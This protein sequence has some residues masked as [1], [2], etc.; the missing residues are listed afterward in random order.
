MLNKHHLLLDLMKLLVEVTTQDDDLKSKQAALWIN[1]ISRGFS[2]LER[3]LHIKLDLMKRNIGT[4]LSVKQQFELIVKVA[5]STY[6][7]LKHA[8]VLKG[9]LPHP[10]EFKEVLEEAMQNPSQH[11]LLFLDS[12]CFMSR[13]PKPPLVQLVKIYV[14]QSNHDTAR[15]NSAPQMS[16]PNS[17]SHVSRVFTV[18]SLL[19]S[20]S[21]ESESH[22]APKK[23]R[24]ELQG[25]SRKGKNESQSVFL[26]RNGH[27]RGDDVEMK[28]ADHGSSEKTNIWTL[29]DGKWYFNL[30]I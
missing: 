30:V 27:H 1:D 12:L 18:E 22:N 2:K 19:K 21:L 7:K 16:R 5:D 9:K 25:A 24:N 11:T 3:C 23:R 14:G 4:E 20:K 8:I 28:D 13:I 15:P 6:T 29:A 10:S 26:H 17:A